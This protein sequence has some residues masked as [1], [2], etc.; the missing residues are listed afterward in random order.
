[1]AGDRPPRTN[2][3]A[4]IEPYPESGRE[5]ILS[6]RELGWL[7]EAL[8]DTERQAAEVSAYEGKVRDVRRRFAAARAVNDRKT[9]GAARREIA[10]L[11]ASRPAAAVPPQAILCFRLL[12]FTGARCGE[13]QTLQW[14][15]VDFK[16]AEVRLPDSKTGAKTVHIPPP[17]LDLLA[18]GTPDRGQQARH[19]RRARGCVLRGPVQVLEANP[20]RRDG[21][22]M[23]G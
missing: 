10:Q 18:K 6:A 7:G 14:P 8:A 13:I 5:R 19:Y 11:R 23:D 20:R 17:A 4:G 21:K 15:W 16:R 9:G 22:V 2:P 1:M 12:F 3:T